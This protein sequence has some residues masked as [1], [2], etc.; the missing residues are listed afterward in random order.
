MN[1]FAPG[2]KIRST[3]VGSDTAT[4]ISSGTSFST[5]FVAGVVATYISERFKQKQAILQPADIIRD[6]TSMATGGV[7]HGLD[8]S[9][10]DLLLYNGLDGESFSTQKNSAAHG[11]ITVSK[12]IIVGLFLPW[13]NI[14]EMFL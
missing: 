5:P 6:I 14:V 1:L 9:S 7:I 12:W 8:S 3:W 2:V 11:R 4:Y 13:L 10:P